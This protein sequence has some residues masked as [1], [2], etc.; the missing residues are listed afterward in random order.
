MA[1]NNSRFTAIRTNTTAAATTYTSHSQLGCETVIARYAS[2]TSTAIT[3]MPSST[4]SEKAPARAG[5]DA[6]GWLDSAWSAA[7]SACRVENSRH[8]VTC[9]SLSIL[10][11]FAAFGSC[12]MRTRSR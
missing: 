2:S 10:Y 9:S 4:S 7:A 5:Q 12:A 6:S 11:L 1:G 3:P 8:D